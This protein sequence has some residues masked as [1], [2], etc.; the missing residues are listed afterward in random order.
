MMAV[1]TVKTP[2]FHSTRQR[3]RSEDFK[4]ESARKILDAS[5]GDDQG[6]KDTF[7]SFAG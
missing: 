5:F 4:H 3:F 6:A 7:A 2:F 1:G